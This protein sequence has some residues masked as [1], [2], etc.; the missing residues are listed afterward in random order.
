MLSQERFNSI[1][2][3]AV[4]SIGVL[5][6]AN[7]Q[8]PVGAYVGLIDWLIIILQSVGRSSAKELEHSF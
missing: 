4:S 3:G 5:P 2:R 1:D 6:T 7:L 8:Y